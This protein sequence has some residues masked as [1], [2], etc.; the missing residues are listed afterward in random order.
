MPYTE[1]SIRESVRI[2]PLNPLGIP[3][4]CM[5]DTILRGYFIPKDAIVLANVWTAHKDT[6]KFGNNVEQFMPERFLDENGN[7]LKKD[8]TMGF[9]AGLFLYQKVKLSLNSRF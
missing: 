1:A 3:R 4:R 5:Q 9:G 2:I 7:L 6:K 8:Y